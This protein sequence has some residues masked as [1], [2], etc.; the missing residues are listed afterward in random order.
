MTQEKYTRDILRRVGMQDCKPVSTPLSVSDKL[1]AY[2]G[3]PLTTNDATNFCSIIDPLQYLT[4]TRPDLSF[5]VNKVCQFLQAP[6]DLHWMAVKRILRYLQHTMAFGLFIRPCKSVLVSAF[7]DVDWAG[8]VDDRRS[9]GGFAVFFGSN[10]ISWNARKQANVSR[11][12]TE[13]EYKYLAN[14]TAELIWIQSLL[15]EL[16]VPQPRIPC[17]WCDNIGATYR[18]LIQFFM[19]AR[20]MWKLIFILFGNGWLVASLT[21]GSSVLKIKLQMDLQNLLTIRNFSNFGDI[22]I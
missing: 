17:L 12:S 2:S 7:S 4:L 21:Y 9:T 1:S 20:N 18:L 15:T 3:T 14:A 8:S 11:S 13:A 10:L 5:P 6:T 19:A 16:K 22:S